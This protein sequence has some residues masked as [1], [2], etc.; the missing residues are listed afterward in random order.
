MIDLFSVDSG[1]GSLTE[2]LR[3]ERS[4]D[5]ASDTETDSEPVGSRI[6]DTSTSSDG[7]ATSCL[8]VTE[9]S[10]SW[11]LEE[12]SRPESSSEV[13]TET[14]GSAS[15]TTRSASKTCIH[16]YIYIRYT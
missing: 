11:R 3:S 8:S 16:P 4:V 10:S 13:V 1:S 15:K 7:S 9:S 2:G 6:G 5:G 14:A 12:L